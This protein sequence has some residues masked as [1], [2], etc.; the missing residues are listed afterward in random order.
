VYVRLVAFCDGIYENS[1][2]S[3][4]KAPLVCVFFIYY[5][6]LFYIILKI[7]NT[8]KIYFLKLCLDGLQNLKQNY[9][10]FDKIL[11]KF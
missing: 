7:T 3:L 9:K 5:I 4:I 1:T 11:I 10:K 8:K 2:C 6:L